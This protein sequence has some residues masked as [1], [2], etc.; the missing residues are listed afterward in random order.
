MFI[1]I[2]TGLLSKRGMVGQVDQLARDVSRQDRFLRNCNDFVVNFSRLSDEDGNAK[3]LYNDDF[4][5]IP[6]DVVFLRIYLETDIGG[7]FPH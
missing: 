6:S 1:I 7:S 3:I 2:K 4:P 5:Q